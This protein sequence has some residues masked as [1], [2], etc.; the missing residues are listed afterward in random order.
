MI[1]DSRP[2]KLLSL[3]L[4]L[5]SPSTSSS[6]GQVLHLGWC[7]LRTLMTL[8]SPTKV[9]SYSR[10]SRWFKNH[11]KVNA[12][13]TDHKKTRKPVSRGRKNIDS[14]ITEKNES[15]FTFHAKQK[16]SF[17]RQEKSIE[18]P[19]ICRYVLQLYSGLIE[20]L[21]DKRFTDNTSRHGASG[22]RITF[23]R[24]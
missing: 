8:K 6:S 21:W 11:A 7:S 9:K 19:Q 10:K 14:R 3:W 16:C 17:T 1:A 24:D 4:A 13:F 18:N 20:I 5:S 2:S 12:Y 23:N 15:S 22:L